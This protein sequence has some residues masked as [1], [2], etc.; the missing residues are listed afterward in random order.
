MSAEAHAEEIPDFAL[1]KV[2][3]WPLWGNAGYFGIEAIHHDAEPQPLLEA[4]GKEVI[5]HLKARFAGVPIDA[6]DV[7]Q[8][9]VSGLLQRTADRAD[10][11]ARDPEGQFAAVEAGIGDAGGL[12]GQQGSDGV[13][14]RMRLQNRVPLVG[15]VH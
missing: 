11:I 15:S 12:D 6:G 14:L 13:V 1:I 4:V 3:R 2:G 5:G 9:V 8:E 7:H 10:V